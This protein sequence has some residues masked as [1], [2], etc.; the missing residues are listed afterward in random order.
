MVKVIKYIYFYL[1]TRLKYIGLSMIK[2]VVIICRANQLVI[3]EEEFVNLYINLYK[4]LLDK[5][6]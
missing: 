2:Y 5:K 4:I 1:V 6:K 3:I